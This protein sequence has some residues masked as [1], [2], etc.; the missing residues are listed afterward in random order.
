MRCEAFL[1]TTISLLGALRFGGG[2][3]FVWDDGEGGQRRE[4]DTRLCRDEM[5]AFGVIGRR[6]GGR[7]GLACGLGF[8]RD[9]GLALRVSESPPGFHSRPRRRFAT[10][11]YGRD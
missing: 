7:G 1:K 10:L 8:R 5:H 2:R 4:E 6:R 9:Q 11:P 3:F